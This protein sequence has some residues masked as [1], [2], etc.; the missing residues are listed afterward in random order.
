MVHVPTM[1]Y[2]S[3]LKWKKILT[4]ATTWMN[5]ED[6]MLSEISQ[7]PKDKNCM[8]LLIRSIPIVV[9]FAE[10]ESRIV[11]TRG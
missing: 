11:F 7:S 6:I 4:H 10:S 2:Y 3:A 9:K 1:E 5:L 8:T